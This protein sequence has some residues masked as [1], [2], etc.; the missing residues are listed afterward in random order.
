MPPRRIWLAFLAALLANFVMM[1]VFFPAPQAITVPYT[2]FK[3][4]VANHNVESIYSRGESI[5]GRFKTSV[6]WPPERKEAAGEERAPEPQP[7]PGMRFGFPAQSE[8]RTSTHF[9][10]RC[11]HSSIPGSR[12]S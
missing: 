4:E 12:R 7:R 6:T 1:R 10:P 5:E 8:P 2:T 11:R 3:Q 9:R